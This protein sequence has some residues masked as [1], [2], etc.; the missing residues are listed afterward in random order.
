MPFFKKQ[1]IDG[2]KYITKL[3]FKFALKKNWQKLEKF[4]IS[5]KQENRLISY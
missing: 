2:I 1:A 5:V 3:I 4:S